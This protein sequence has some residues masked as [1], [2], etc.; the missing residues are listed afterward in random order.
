MNAVLGLDFSTDAPETAAQIHAHAT[1]AELRGVL[2]APHKGAVPNPGAFSYKATKAKA[3]K[4]KKRRPSSDSRSRKAGETPPENGDTNKRP[5]SVQR[6]L[7]PLG[8]QL[9]GAMFNIAKSRTPLDPKSGRKKCWAFSCHSGCPFSAA[10]CK[11]G[12]H[13]AIYFGPNTDPCLKAALK[14]WG[15]VKTGP[16][17]S[18]AAAVDKA[19]QELLTKVKADQARGRAEGGTRDVPPAAPKKEGGRS[20]VGSR[21]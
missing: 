2:P 8:E 5:R 15:G 18:D 21:R 20:C 6:H 16:Q 7:Y 17:L 19:V 1:D 9:P 14:R 4:T 11:H 12:A 3:T 10:E 13:V